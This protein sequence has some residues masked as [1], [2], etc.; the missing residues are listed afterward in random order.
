MS[1]ESALGC[2]LLA[3]ATI[4]LSDKKDGTCFDILTSTSSDPVCLQAPSKEDCNLWIAKITESQ[5]LARGALSSSLQTSSNALKLPAEQ[6]PLPSPLSPVAAP[7]PPPE[8]TTPNGAQPQSLLSPV[9]GVADLLTPKRSEGSDHYV[10]VTYCSGMANGGVGLFLK[11]SD[12]KVVIEKILEGSAKRH[13]GLRVGDVVLS[14]NGTNTDNY[15]ATDCRN[16]IV[17]PQGSVV[18]VQIDRR[19]EDP[20]DSP[21][22]SFRLVRAASSEFFESSDFCCVYL[23]IQLR[24][25]RARGRYA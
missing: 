25:A 23:F 8:L 2:I 5:Q 12:G 15:T 10:Y 11:S 17:G 1:V 13:G 9:G 18:V 14:I 6:P 20:V 3:D 24:F 21:G 4:M 16:L 19:P 22:H 7:A